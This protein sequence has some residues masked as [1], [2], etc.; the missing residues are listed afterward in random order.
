[1]QVPKK[2]IAYY[3]EP[4]GPGDS[5][6]AGMSLSEQQASMRRF[7]EG[8]TAAMSFVERPDRKFK[9]FPELEKAI[10][11]AQEQN[12]LLVIVQL[13][14]LARYPE[15]TGPL[16]NSKVPLRCLDQPSI[17]EQTLI[18]VA[19]H[20]LA[21]RKRHSLRIRQG[22]ERTLAQLGNPNAAEEIRRIN[23]TKIEQAVIFAVLLQPIIE[24]YQAV[25]YSQRRMVEELNKAG[26]TAPEGG[27]WVLSQLQKVLDRIQLNELAI[28][29]ASI[30][31]DPR[32]QGQ[33]ES[34]LLGVLSLTGRLPP[35]QTEWDSYGLKQVRN[36][37][38]LLREILEFHQFVLDFGPRIDEWVATGLTDSQIANNLNSMTVSVPAKVEK[39]AEYQESRRQTE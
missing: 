9:C 13:Q 38:S 37:L 16:I 4:E 26:Y 24:D 12:A 23:E 18:A 8:G 6:Y 36:R 11:A 7:L 27:Q 22:L 33:D 19:E 3:W 34:V 31:D 20:A 15:F 25:G 17:N 14:H 5:N 1:M 21:E 29:V 28:A 2:F 10:E 39:A 32:Y 35:H 30:I